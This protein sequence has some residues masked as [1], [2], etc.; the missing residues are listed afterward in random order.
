MVTGGVTPLEGLPGETTCGEI[1]PSI[2][3]ALAS[4]ETSPGT[5]MIN[6][7]L[8]R[9]SGLSAV[10]GRR[11]TIGEL[12]HST[13][14]SLRLAYDILRYRILLACGAAKAAMGDVEA[15][16]ASGRYAGEAGQ[17][18]E[19]LTERLAKGR[20]RTGEAV[21]WELFEEELPRIIADRAEVAVSE[22]RASALPR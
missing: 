7:V 12:L 10:A 8:T 18:L 19:W 14:P 2:V 1:D 13:D 16:V 3:L 22:A 17:L 4:Q 9:Q 21:P 6:L 11:I 20:G 5:E 15:V